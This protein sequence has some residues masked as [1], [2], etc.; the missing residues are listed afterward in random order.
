[1][2]SSSIAR[3][4][5]FASSR[6]LSW[7]SFCTLCNL[8][9]PSVC[10]DLSWFFR[11]CFS[12]SLSGCADLSWFFRTRFYFLSIGLRRSIGR[13]TFPLQLTNNLLGDELHRSIFNGFRE[14]G[15]LGR[16]SLKCFSKW[17]LN[18]FANWSMF[19]CR[20][21]IF[22]FI[23]IEIV[24][25]RDIRWW[26]RRQISLFIQHLSSLY[27]STSGIQWVGNVLW[28]IIAFDLVW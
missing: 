25:W 16:T 12:S 11:T 19:N 2:F 26:T 5:L 6:F 3:L 22:S 17:L 7:P 21:L 9:S 10:S 1:M 15:W 18:E 24:S 4:N 27:F 14:L 13:T 23:P 28:R 20:T 8:S